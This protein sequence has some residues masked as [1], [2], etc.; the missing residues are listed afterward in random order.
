[1]KTFWRR[2][3]AYQKVDSREITPV[4]SNPRGLWRRPGAPS[5]PKRAGLHGKRAY[6]RAFALDVQGGAA[7]HV[8]S[9]TSTNG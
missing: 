5:P 1:M 9:W 4:L 7:R 3:C 8:G 2:R 6:E